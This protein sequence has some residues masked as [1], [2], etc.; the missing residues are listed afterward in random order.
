MSET[1]F[2]IG[3]CGLDL[4]DDFYP[5]DLPSEWR[6]D[7]YSTL[8][9]ALSLPIDSEEDFELIFEELEDSDEEFELV[10]TIQPQQLL[11]VKTLRNLLSSVE[12]YQSLFTLSVELDQAPSAEVMALL[13]GYRLSFQSTVK[14]K[15]E[16]TTA[17]AMGQYLY[18]THLPVFHLQGDGDDKQMRANIEKIAKI[19]TRT[20]LICND[21]ESDALNKL[22]TIAEILGY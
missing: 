20:V 5:D 10:L 13:T 2:L 17:E 11:D 4:V 6:F 15:S 7:Y 8:F 19:N 21:A 9:K 3:R 22:R 14:Y 12:L 16:L 1:E 18:Y